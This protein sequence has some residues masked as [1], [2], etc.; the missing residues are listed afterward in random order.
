MVVN[1]WGAWASRTSREVG[2]E[3]EVVLVS[4]GD[5]LLT[6]VLVAGVG[7]G[8]VPYGAR[9]GRTVESCGVSRVLVGLCGWVFVEV[10]LVVPPS[11]RLGSLRDRGLQR[12]RGWRGVLTC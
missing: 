5:A 11:I 7:Y 12:E 10:A 3:H 1:G 9:K 8:Q 2:G 4:C 6:L